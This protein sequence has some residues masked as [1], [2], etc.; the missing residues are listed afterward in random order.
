[1]TCRIPRVSHSCLCQVT[2]VSSTHCQCP[3]RLTDTLLALDTIERSL[4]NRTKMID[5]ALATL[6][7]EGKSS[8]LLVRHGE[9]LQQG[10]R[11]LWAQ[12]IVAL[13]PNLSLEE[14][15]IDLPLAHDGLKQSLEVAQTIRAVFTV[16]RYLDS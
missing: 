14:A 8:L 4:D 1:M 15:L 6:E 11:E 2:S 16:K 9:I 7:S 10:T 12:D 3:L 13:N 5:D